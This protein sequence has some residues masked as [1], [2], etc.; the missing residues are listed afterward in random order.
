M[1]TH[2]G[3]RNLVL[4][5]HNPTYWCILNHLLILL[6]LSILKPVSWILGQPPINRSLELSQQALKRVRCAAFE[7]ADNSLP[8]ISFASTTGLFNCV[9]YPMESGVQI[10]SSTL[11]IAINDFGQGV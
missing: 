6:S 3:N 2:F 11:R 1:K 4:P 5:L 10:T 9:R 8:Y 7:V